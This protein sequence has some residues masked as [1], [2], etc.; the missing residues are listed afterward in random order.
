M[1]VENGFVI[2][3]LLTSADTT[4]D[5]GRGLT[6]LL[7]YSNEEYSNIQMRRS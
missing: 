4:D 2:R 1:N 7:K 5:N 6:F 3:W